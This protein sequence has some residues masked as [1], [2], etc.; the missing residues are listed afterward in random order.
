MN[1]MKK[2]LV[3]GIGEFLWDILPDGKKA[4]GAPV[5]FTYYASKSGVRA[6]AFSAVGDDPLGK[7]LLKTTE[8]FG[9]GIRATVTE[10]PT[11]TVDVRLKDGIPQYHINENVAWD[12]IRLTDEMISLA[13]EA[14]AICYGTL[15]QRSRVSRDTIASIVAATPADAYRIFDINIRQQFYS[16]ELIEKNLQIS[17]VLKINDEEFDLIKRLFHLEGDSDEV[18]RHIMS[19]WDLRLLILTAGAQ[20]SSVYSGDGLSRIRTPEVEVADTVGAGDSFTGSFIGSVLNGKS[21]REAHEA[22]VKT[23]AEVCRHAG[24]WIAL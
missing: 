8:E 13:A 9:I 16:T 15:A 2:P 22:A 11:G 3:L 12:H 5:N 21:V 17:N 23:A 1:D 19:R 20:Y 10:Y 14:S 18:C 4:G 6:V 7:E 24:A